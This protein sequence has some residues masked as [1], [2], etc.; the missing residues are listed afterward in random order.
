MS[1]Y[2]M[3]FDYLTHRDFHQMMVVV[4]LSWFIYRVDDSEFT[5]ISTF[6]EDFT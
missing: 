2:N 4:L 5:I 1:D 3:A 6:I